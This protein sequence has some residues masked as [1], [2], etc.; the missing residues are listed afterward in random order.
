MKIAHFGPYALAEEGYLRCGIYEAARDMMW[1][2]TRR[3]HESIFVDLGAVSN[4]AREERKV[5]TVD[6]RGGFRSVVRDFE[7]AVDADLF[8]AHDSIPDDFLARTHAPVIFIM[9]GRPL[10]CFRSEVNCNRIAYSF[11]FDFARRDRV[12]AMV[13]FWP[14]HV[15]FWRAL[16]PDDKLVCL[17][18]PPVDQTRYSPDGPVYEIPPEKK[19]AFNVLVADAWRTDIDCYEIVHA[20]MCAAPSIP[21][22][23][24]H[25]YALEIPLPYPWELIFHHYRQLGIQGETWARAPHM[26]RV[27]RG[28]DAVLT[29]HRIATRIVNE[30]LSCGTP[31]VAASGCS[32]TPYTGRPEDPESMAA[33]LARLYEDWRRDPA[34]V[35]AQALDAARAFEPLA[36]GE[37]MDRVYCEALRH[38]PN[39]GDALMQSRPNRLVNRY[40]LPGDVQQ[41]R[42]ATEIP[43]LWDEPGTVLYVGANPL[44]FHLGQKLYGHGHEVTL[45]EVFEPNAD[46]YRGFRMTPHVVR[47]DVRDVGELDLPHDRY[48]A[49][50]WWHGPEHLDRDEIAPA[51]E[52]L[53][54]L[55]RKVV[56]LASPWGDLPQDAADGN[57][58]EIHRCSLYPED[59]WGWGYEVKAFGVPDSLA[60]GR[61]NAWKVVG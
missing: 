52:K 43:G 45:L 7:D 36:F 1:I 55:A 17:D 15:P 22:L 14:E 53:E 30:A 24:A 41:V 13:T 6:D 9:H 33:A 23:K 28:M 4:N 34:A 39:P 59:Y 8:V 26:N 44:R 51:L 61:L 37:R 3:G 32:Y 18:H 11:Q 20:P 42:A 57:E 12:R 60:H 31:V 48:D 2:D 27:Y 10:D 21:G 47:G 49:V 58:A 35:K 46:A 50:V 54:A 16:V 5:G 29:P 38:G 19:G 40:N 56:V 25:I